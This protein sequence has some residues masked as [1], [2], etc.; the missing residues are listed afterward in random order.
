MIYRYLH[1]NILDSSSPVQTAKTILQFG[2]FFVLPRV[3]QHF[4]F[5]NFFL[6]LLDS[7]FQHLVFLNHLEL[8]R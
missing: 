4:K 2:G 6:K 3:L 7:F 8:E 1:Q 5:L